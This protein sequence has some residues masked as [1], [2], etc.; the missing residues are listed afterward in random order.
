MSTGRDCC[1]LEAVLISPAAISWSLRQLWVLWGHLWLPGD[2]FGHHGASLGLLG[3]TCLGLLISC[4][5]QAPF[6]SLQLLGGVAK[7]SRQWERLDLAF[8]EGK[9][10]VIRPQSPEATRGTLRVMEV[11]PGQ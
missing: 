3:D 6:W 9:C 1:A 4:A 8:L 10:E 5:P 11:I 2:S 7:S